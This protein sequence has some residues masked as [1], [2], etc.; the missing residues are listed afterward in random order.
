MSNIQVSINAR[1]RCI[2]FALL[3]AEGHLTLQSLA[4]QTSLS[5]R[6][7][8][9]NLDTVRAWFRSQNVALIARPGYGLELDAPRAV[10]R[11]LLNQISEA[12]ESQLILTRGQRHRITLFELL[13]A[14]KPITYQR[15]SINEGISRS[16]IIHDVNAMQAWLNVHQLTLKRTPNK[17]SRI[18]GSELS[19]RFALL[20]LIREELGEGKWFSLW[21][22]P[23]LGP[24]LDKSLPPNLEKYLKRLPFAFAQTAVHHVENM[25]GERLALYSR[26]EV[27]VYLA[28]TIDALQ[29]GSFHA[30]LEETPDPGPCPEMQVSRFVF[31]EINRKYNL[32]PSE[33]EQRLLAICLLGSKWELDDRARTDNAQPNA[34]QLGEVSVQYASEIVRLCSSQLHP[35]LWVDH[36][37][38]TSLARHLKPVIH[39][40][41]YNLP[42]VNHNADEVR[43]AFPEVYRSARAA[44]WMIERD[45]GKPVSHEELGYLT[46]YLAAAL[47]RLRTRDRQNH[48]VVL[49]G[50]GVRAKALYLK[51]R[52]E[53]EFPNLEVTA[54]RSG[55]TIEPELLAE[56]DLIL[57]MIPNLTPD[58]GDVPIIVTSPF[59]RPA[60]KRLLQNWI[61]E[62]EQQLHRIVP[63]P[64]ESPTL[65]DLLTPQTI[66]FAPRAG[67]WQQ[68]VEL[69][70]QPLLEIGAIRPQY[71]TAMIKVIEEYGPY[72]VLAPGVIMLHARPVD[73]VNQL[74]L[75]MLRLDQGVPFDEE[76]GPIDIAFV[77]GATD[78]HSHIDALL[79]LSQLIEQ[80]AFCEALRRAQRPADV[81]RAIWTYSMEMQRG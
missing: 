73:G 8:R 23:S 75:S 64:A 31:A 5:P 29:Q 80:P 25:M 65:V 66:A 51:S 42:I 2:I 6:I 55:N 4:K 52:L 34:S 69:A 12:D 38:L 56:T 63:R 43:H 15:L 18:L 32:E 45:L 37:L 28:I 39:R 79:Q 7:I 10:R 77:L 61:S 22:D 11:R 72:M 60:E 76:T 35:L 14:E 50:D 17:G 57:S 27:L 40:I 74:C 30:K 26:V 1:Q 16:T 48:R 58:T 21:F 53:F 68:V 67:S 70:S 19:R 54:I 33:A 47:N 41:R 9:Y 71:C 24:V 78:D 46:L 3:Q 36:D 59:L 62:R 13:T 81:L 20:N 44:V 49:L